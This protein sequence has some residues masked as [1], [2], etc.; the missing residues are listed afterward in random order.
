MAASEGDTMSNDIPITVS[1]LHT[2]EKPNVGRNAIV[3][4]M[5][6]Y[7]AGYLKLILQGY[8][9][10]GKAERTREVCEELLERMNDQIDW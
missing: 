10:T 4:S 2:D 8:M 3:I 6:R 9:Q 1:E 5:T 7:H